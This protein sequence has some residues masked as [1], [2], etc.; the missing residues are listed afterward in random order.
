[1]TM[2]NFSENFVVKELSV[3][4]QSANTL[5]NF[6]TFGIYGRDFTLDSVGASSSLQISVLL[7][8]AVAVIATFK[9]LL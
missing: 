9:N 2:S 5:R 1:M 7:T 4:M 3:S 8:A 6:Y